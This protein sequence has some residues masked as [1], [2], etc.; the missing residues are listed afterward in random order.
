MKMLS[1]YTKLFF[2]ICLSI[3]FLPFSTFAQ[4]ESKPNVSISAYPADPEP[5]SK[6][7]V[8]ITSFETDLGL[9]NIVWTGALP[10][11]SGIG[12]D[13][14]VFNSNNTEEEQNITAKIT[15]KDGIEILKSIIITPSKTDLIYES[16]NTYKPPFYKGKSH[17]TRESLIRVSSVQSGTPINTSSY[18]WKRN[19][20]NIN[21]NKS[22]IDIQN[23]E[24][25]NK[26]L[27][28]VNISNSRNRKEKSLVVPLY[29]PKI[30][31]Y[32]FHPIYGIQH[33]IVIKNSIILYKDIASI[34]AVPLGIEKTN[35]KIATSWKL[36][37]N[38]VN[39]GSVALLLS[40]IRPD[41]SGIVAISLNFENP[42]KFYQSVK[43]SLAI[44]F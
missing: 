20:S 3:A 40:F 39:N 5:G 37:E 32:A 26:E 30:V 27:I 19:G 7:T 22:F 41:E 36:S 15:T 14:F 29:N 8:K 18:S 34:F 44:N 13:T 17:I 9:A 6:V 12:E 2:A 43:N 24:F 42:K 28:T 23:D 25:S 11:L 35:S 1:L 31:F 38:S 10:N 4:F 16:R 33:N 21:S